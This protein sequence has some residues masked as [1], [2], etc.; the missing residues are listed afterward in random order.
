M[1]TISRGLLVA[2]LALTLAA[3]AAADDTHCKNGR[4]KDAGMWFSILHPG[5]GEYYLKGWGPIFRKGPQRKFWYGF[6]P[7]FGWPGYLQVKSARDAWKCRTN[8]RLFD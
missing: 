8:D 7:I 4:S 6:V 3:P 5:L 1:G 2:A